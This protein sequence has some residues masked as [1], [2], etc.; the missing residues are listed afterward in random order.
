[1]AGVSSRPGSRTPGGCDRTSASQNPDRHLE[2]LRAP[3]PS[4][5]DED[6]GDFAL[7][8]GEV[9]RLGLAGSDP[10]LPSM[11]CTRPIRWSRSR[12]KVFEDELPA[13]LL[14]GQI[15]PELPDDQPLIVSSTFSRARLV[16]RP[17]S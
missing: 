15:L 12:L 8:T 13:R 5:S 10:H 7:G 16:V 1:V 17:L 14:H 2:L 9:V 11:P 6:P 4:L 3:L